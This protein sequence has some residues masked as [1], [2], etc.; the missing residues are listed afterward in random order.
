[1]ARFGKEKLLMLTCLQLAD[2]EGSG[3]PEQIRSKQELEIQSVKRFQDLVLSMN[4][5]EEVLSEKD[6]AIGG[7]DLIQLGYSQGPEIGNV[8]K[9]LTK[10]VMEER[11]DNTPE[12]LIEEA[13]KIKERIHK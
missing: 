11:M 5:A 7:K 13:K 12:A 9:R 4:P 1:M 10:L 6:I 3:M 2:I 8:L